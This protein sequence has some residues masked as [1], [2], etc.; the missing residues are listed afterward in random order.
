LHPRSHK[1]EEP[2]VIDLAIGVDRAVSGLRGSLG[3]VINLEL[4]DGGCLCGVLGAVNS[5]VLILE[6]WD[7]STSGPNGDPYTVS[8]SQVRRI[9]VL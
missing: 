9:I 7:K 6:H 4:C 5:D 3:M 8:I 1:N 2:E